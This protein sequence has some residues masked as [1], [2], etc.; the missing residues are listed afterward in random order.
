[1]DAVDLARRINDNLHWSRSGVLKSAKDEADRPKDTWG[2]IEALW[3]END[4]AFVSGLYFT[5][6]GRPADPD[7]LESLCNAM[8]AGMKRADVVRALVLSDE[9]RSKNLDVSWLYRLS[10]A[11][12]LFSLAFLKAI[13][14]RLAAVRPKGFWSRVKNRLRRMA[15]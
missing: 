13:I 1:M 3:P 8:A 2:Q 15:C 9:A 4:Y 10:G 6:L 12:P 14:R 11:P 7:G 5:C